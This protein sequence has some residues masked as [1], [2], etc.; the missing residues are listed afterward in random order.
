LGSLRTDYPEDLSAQHA[1]TDG[2]R[3]VC[4]LNTGS[5]EVEQ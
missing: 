3:L 4:L 5:L 1:L 2:E